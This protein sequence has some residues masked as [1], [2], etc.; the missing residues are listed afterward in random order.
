MSEMN[1][2][3]VDT[4]IARKQYEKLTEVSNIMFPN[5]DKII[6]MEY[7]GDNIRVM[8][9]ENVVMVLC[10]FDG[11]VIQE[12]AL[13]EAIVNGTIFDDAERVSHHATYL[14]N[15]MLPIKGLS[16]KHGIE[17]TKMHIMISSVI[18]TMGDDGAIDIT[19]SDMNNGENFIKDILKCD[20]RAEVNKMCHHYMGMD[21]DG[22]HDVDHHPL[23]ME[24]RKDIGELTKEIDAII[25]V[26]P[27]DVLD[28][29]DFDILDIDKEKEED[30]DNNIISESFLSKKPKKL[31]PIPRDVVV[32]IQVEINAIRDS[33]DQAML[34]GYT[35]SKL[36][37]VDFYLNCI[38]TNDA[39]YIVPHD[40]QYL[41]TMQKD[42]N[43]CLQRIL[44]IR[45][46]NR[47]DRVWNII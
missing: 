28:D 27:D 7:D 24:L 30:D 8:K 41:I 40:R 26:D 16:H 42:L 35:S 34:A 21:D 13:A 33:N 6:V 1:R 18:G 37:L 22:K 5:N 10:P 32:Y 2:Q 14:Q 11:N 38:D 4:F 39:R 29:D 15:S 9:R 46:V 12:S 43:D 44:K 20:D 19:V 3:I 36:E 17:P 47:A 25:D 23:P 31:K 45:P